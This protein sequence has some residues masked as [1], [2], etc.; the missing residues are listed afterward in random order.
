MDD[1][2]RRRWLLLA[3]VLVPLLVLLV[4][5]LLV[6]GQ[7]EVLPWQPEPTRVPIVP[8]EGLSDSPI[9]GAPAH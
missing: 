1:R 5:G 7:A 9:R 4:A 6:A 3:A 8:F 2:R